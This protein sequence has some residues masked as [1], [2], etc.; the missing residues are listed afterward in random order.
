MGVAY[1]FSHGSPLTAPN[2]AD[3]SHQTLLV[4]HCDLPRHAH[5]CVDNMN[6][7]HALSDSDILLKVPVTCRN[8]DVLHWRTH[9]L[10]QT[11]VSLAARSLVSMS[12]YFTDE[13]GKALQMQTDWTLV[14]HVDFW[15][16]APVA[17]ILDTAKR[18]YTA[19]NYLAMSEMTKKRGNVSTYEDQD[20][21]SDEQDGRSLRKTRPGVRVRVRTGPKPRKNSGLQ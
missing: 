4:M 1:A 12:V 6:P 17:S 7:D 19:V 10:E 20:H 3:M 14:F 8:Y 5:C 11:R 18:I 13:Y 15:A 16:A 2:V 21:G 9:E